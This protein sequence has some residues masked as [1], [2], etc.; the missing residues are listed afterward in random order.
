MPWAPTALKG[1]HYLTTCLLPCLGGWQAEKQQLPQTAGKVPPGRMP[2]PPHPVNHLLGGRSGI[3]PWWDLSQ[4]SLT[5]EQPCSLRTSGPTCRSV[6]CGGALSHH[7]KASGALKKAQQ[8]ASLHTA[9]GQLGSMGGKGETGG[10]KP[11]KAQLLSPLTSMCPPLPLSWASEWWFKSQ[12][13]SVGLKESL[14]DLAPGSCHLP[15]RRESTEENPGLLAQLSGMVAIQKPAARLWNGLPPNSCQLP[16]ASPPPHPPP[17]AQLSP[18]QLWAPLP[19]PPCCP[20]GWWGQREASG[21]QRSLVSLFLKWDCPVWGRG[22]W[23]LFPSSDLWEQG[24]APPLPQH[25]PQD[26]SDLGIEGPI[27]RSHFCSTGQIN[28]GIV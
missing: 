12:Q 2:P 24:A 13:P 7:G 14:L 21:S 4:F 15:L 20:T 16:I 17:S 26:Q 23:L 3:V 11:L 22:R 8:P 25:I 6:G 10:R 19:A 5:R 9:L 28:P 27:P 18:A 1:A